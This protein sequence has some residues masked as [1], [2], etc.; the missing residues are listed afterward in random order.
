MALSQ[1]SK[2][3]SQNH[4]LN[5]PSAQNERTSIAKIAEIVDIGIEIGT[6]IVAEIVTE[7]D[8][9]TIARTADAEQFSLMQKIGRA[10]V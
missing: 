10:H 3:E 4:A 2:Y 6:V 5:V 1:L 8:L 9:A 7:A